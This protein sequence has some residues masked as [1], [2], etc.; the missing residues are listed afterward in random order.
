MEC[1]SKSRNV[2]CTLNFSTN[3]RI[4]FAYS[5]TF[6]YVFSFGIAFFFIFSI[7]WLSHSRLKTVDFHLIWRKID[8]KMFVMCVF[9]VYECMTQHS[10]KCERYC[11]NVVCIDEAIF[12]MECV[13]LVEFFFLLNLKSHHFNKSFVHC[14]K[15]WVFRMID[16][17]VWM[18]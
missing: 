14:G 8:S 11:D 6:I 2:Q 10:K 12:N 15:F 13:W 4:H 7:T 17:K 16:W 5:T 3:I 18:E 1:N 9:F